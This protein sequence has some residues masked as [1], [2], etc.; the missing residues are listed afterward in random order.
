MARR[1]IRLFLVQ[2]AQGLTPS[3]G[4]YKANRSLLQSL[5]RCGDGVTVAQICYGFDDEVKL[6]ANRAKA[7]GIDP[8]VEGWTIP[9]LTDEG[10]TINI[11]IKTFTDEDRIMN[12]VI[13][14]Q[15]YN[16]VYPVR[17]LWQDTKNYLEG[18]TPS[19][20]LQILIDL[21]SAQIS[22][23][24]PT[25][26][27][28]N[29]ALTMKI[30]SEMASRNEFKRICVIHTAEQLPFGPYCGGIFGHCT[31]P[32]IEDKLLRGLDGIWSVSKA[33]QKYA[34]DYG[35]LPTKFMV[36]ST[37]SYLDKET[38]GMP[39][40][41]NNVDKFEVG[42]VNPCPHKGLHILLQLAK[43]LP[44]VK[45][46]TWTSWGSQEVHL[47]ML[48]AMP[49]IAIEPTTRNTDEIWDRIRVLLAPSVWLEAWGII[50]TEAQLRG[51]PV[52]AS[53]AGGLAEAKLG[54]KYCIPVKLVTGERADEG[55]YV[56]P[57]QDLAPW[58]ESIETLVFDNK[59]YEELA[60]E[61]ALKTAK[62]LNSLDD[63]EHEKWLTS[64]MDDKTQN[65]TELTNGTGKID[66]VTI[67]G[68]NKVENGDNVSNSIDVQ[69][70]TSIHTVITSR[71]G[72]LPKSDHTEGSKKA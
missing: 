41:R 29:D 26:V 53:N 68:N 58:V 20:R 17:E 60:A 32:A 50:V 69:E 27:M 3:S 42:M 46:V 62:W 44:H 34:W 64:M 23:F 37:L 72:N 65:E 33:I 1:S 9:H 47:D 43:A 56:V 38:G 19:G 67:T 24:E 39:L 35:K 11:S 25:H 55:D 18:Q 8:K 15:P 22:E 59:A 5:T 40:V 10:K 30:T 4:G 12:V 31:S 54:L 49:N 28:F 71:N 52:I 2:T 51:I 36:H 70:Q 57:D 45:F 14:R 21:F 7:K 48:R 66:T 13:V 16:E 61:T 6:L 63:R